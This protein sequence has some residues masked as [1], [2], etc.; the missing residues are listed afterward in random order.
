MLLMKLGFSGYE[1]DKTL[2][3]V[4]LM[5]FITDKLKLNLNTA[6]LNLYAN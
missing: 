5:K 2:K 3:V 4:C 1:L 6:H